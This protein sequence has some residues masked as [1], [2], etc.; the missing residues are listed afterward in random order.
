MMYPG[1]WIEK[2]YTE[3]PTRISQIDNTVYLRRNIEQSGDVWTAEERAVP[4][5]TYNSEVY[6]HSL[7]LDARAESIVISSEYAAA[8]IPQT[9][10]LMTAAPSAASEETEG[11]QPLTPAC[12]ETLAQSYAKLIKEGKRTIDDVLSN[13]PTL[14]PRVE[15]LLREPNTEKEEVNENDL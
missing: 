5:E 1:A 9:R 8:I 15:Y 6:S 4:I 14:K 7:T 12:M 2:T 10:M 13:P 3:Q 11:E